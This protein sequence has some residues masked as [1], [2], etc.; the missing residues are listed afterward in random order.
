[1]PKRPGFNPEGEATVDELAE[2][3]RFGER[4]KQPDRI[5]PKTAHDYARRAVDALGDW[6]QRVAAEDTNPDQ[7]VDALIDARA[8]LDEIE[9]AAGVDVAA[10]LHRVHELGRA[11]TEEAMRRDAAT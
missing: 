4:I 5:E 9:R 10:H 7:M 8:Q 3:R 2:L 6:Y 11:R 1:M